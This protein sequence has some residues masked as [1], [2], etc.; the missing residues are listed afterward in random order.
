MVSEKGKR[1]AIR[2]RTRV[3]LIEFGSWLAF[4]L[5][6]GFYLHD[7]WVEIPNLQDFHPGWHGI[8]WGVLFLSIA[9]ILGWA[10]ILTETDF[11][12]RIRLRLQ[13]FIVRRF[14]K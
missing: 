5:G 1:E 6:L 12:F 8:D 13:K 9:W 3:A 14:K 7:R 4:G 10:I 2:R 11:W